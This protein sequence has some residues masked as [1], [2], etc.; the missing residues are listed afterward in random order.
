MNELEIRYLP[1]KSSEFRMEQD[2]NNLVMSGYAAVYNSLSEDLGGFREMI[3]PGAFTRTLAADPDVRLL[4][5][6]EGMPLARTASKTLVL[7]E[8]QRG[9]AFRAVLDPT[10]SDVQ[11]LAPKIKRGDVNQMSFAF[12]CKQDNFR[13]E[14][15]QII[16][17]VRDAELHDGDVSPVCY[18]AY[19][20]TE[21]GV[22]GLEAARRGVQ[23][24]R[25]KQLVSARGMSASLASR[26]IQLSEI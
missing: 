15:D 16:R 24:F 10:D 3:M 26:I 7:T 2:G 8:D 17:E 18:P 6:H 1:L 25:N 20:A 21:V 11:R 13:N 14:G 5:N 12:R 23:E 19:K 4:V 9:L 22:R